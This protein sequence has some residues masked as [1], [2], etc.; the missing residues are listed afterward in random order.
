MS[1]NIKLG[2]DNHTILKKEIDTS[3][4]NRLSYHIH[5]RMKQFGYYD[6]ERERGTILLLIVTEIIKL[7]DENK[8]NR[9]EKVVDIA[10]RLFDYCGHNNI[11][12][13]N[14]SMV[15]TPYSLDKMIECITNEYESHRSDI[16]TNNY[17]IKKCL[18]MCYS[19]AKDNNI[20]LNKE[21]IIKLKKLDKI[22]KMKK[23]RKI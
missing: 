17:Y 20:D 18:Y 12:F 6:K 10:M 9:I 23:L 15:Y 8:L 16:K 21:I 22:Y 11:K 3:F 7:Y 5:N 13:N 19:F 4:F 2:N 1:S 14:K